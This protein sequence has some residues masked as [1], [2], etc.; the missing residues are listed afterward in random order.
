M[1]TALQLL[2]TALAA[3]IAAWGSAFI[4][5]K[6]TTAETT[7]H[8]AGSADLLSQA[9]ARLIPFYDA[10]LKAMEARLNEAMVRLT[11]AEATAEAA[12]ARESACLARTD[13]MQLQIDDLRRQIMS[14]H[15]T[16]TTTTAV[17]SLDVSEPHAK[18]NL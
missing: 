7:H 8:E 6:R 14:P 13:A 5:R 15:T 3:G 11:K 10:S 1:S 18:E 2:L 9:A 17:T 4:V 12:L 16:T